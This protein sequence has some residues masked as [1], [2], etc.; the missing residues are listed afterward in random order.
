M[1]IFKVMFSHLAYLRDPLKGIK[2]VWCCTSRVSNW[3]LNLTVVFLLYNINTVK[4]KRNP[5]PG[6]QICR[7][8]HRVLLCVPH[9]VRLSSS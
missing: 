3:N 8:V 5:L 2:F 9:R 7:T 6:R 1:M 4:C